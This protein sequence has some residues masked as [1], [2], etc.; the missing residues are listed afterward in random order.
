MTDIP[1]AELDQLTHLITLNDGTV[2]LGDS[3]GGVHIAQRALIAHNYE[4][5]YWDFETGTHHHIKLNQWSGAINGKPYTVF[6]GFLP[7][8]NKWFVWHPKE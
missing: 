7:I 5:S 6:L 4:V 3:V 1:L 8:L 2:V